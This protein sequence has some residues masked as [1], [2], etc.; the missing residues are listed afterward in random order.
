ML[1]NL[2][3]GDDVPDYNSSFE[4]VDEDDKP[5]TPKRKRNNKIKRDYQLVREFASATEAQQF[6]KSEKGWSI[7]TTN[8]TVQG[9][10]VLYRCNKNKLRGQQCAAGIHLLYAVESDSV[11]MYQ[12]ENAHTCEENP[13]I[14]NPIDENVKNS[15]SNYSLKGFGNVKTFKRN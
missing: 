8:D 6:I 14:Y 15:W 1:N 2:S 13:R 4:K 7:A 12:A 11:F 5:P 9:K 10:K 3:A